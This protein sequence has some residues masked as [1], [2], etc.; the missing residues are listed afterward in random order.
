MNPENKSSYMSRVYCYKEGEHIII[1]LNEYY[2][3]EAEVKNLSTDE[4]EDLI[5]KPIRN[6]TFEITETTK[7]SWGTEIT[8]KYFVTAFPFYQSGIDYCQCE[9]YRIENTKLR[10]GPVK[11]HICRHILEVR[12]RFFPQVNN[13]H[14]NY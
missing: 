10:T 9:E 4:K 12:K 14:L 8:L 6:N 13:S 3:N 5:I 11:R 1:P 2:S 7:N